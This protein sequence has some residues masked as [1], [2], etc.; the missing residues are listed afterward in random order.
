[1][2]DG[3]GFEP[4]CACAS[5]RRCGIVLHSG[6]GP[7]GILLRKT[8]EA[9][10]STLESFSNR[11][12][13]NFWIP[14]NWT[15]GHGQSG[16]S[17]RAFDGSAKAETYCVAYHLTGGEDE[18]EMVVGGRYLDLLERR[19]D[20]WRIKTKVYALDWNRNVP[21]TANWDDGM[22]GQLRTRGGRYPDDPWYA[23]E[24]SS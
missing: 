18:R 24:E 3:R 19:D 4:E 20:E 16:N 15:I 21:A 11:G 10:W 12:I 6:M 9:S 22:Y 7:E 8:N 13:E 17:D 2:A 1:M 5:G 14:S 23:F